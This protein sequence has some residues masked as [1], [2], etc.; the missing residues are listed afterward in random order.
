MDVGLSLKW[1]ILLLLL[2]CYLNILKIASVRFRG[3]GYF[4]RTKFLEV[5]QNF[6]SLLK[7]QVWFAKNNQLDIAKW[8]SLSLLISSSLSLFRTHT[9]TFT[10]TLTN[11]HINKTH[12]QTHALWQDHWKLLRSE[13][14]W[15]LIRMICCY[16]ELTFPTA[17]T[18]ILK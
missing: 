2:S 18:Y 1:F 6:H 3:S 11:I 12:T 5:P 10:C 7:L 8:F 9:H 16:Y 13:S 15:E 14:C 4:K 17:P